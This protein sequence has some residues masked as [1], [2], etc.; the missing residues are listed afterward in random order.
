MI[1]KIKGWFSD[2]V[3]SRIIKN[4]AYLIAS[5][6]ISVFLT[7]YITRLL[8]VYNYGVLGIITSYVTNVNRF[9]SFRMNE[10]VV[11]YV[12]EPFE[13]MDYQ[14]AGALIKFGALIETGTSILSFLFLAATANLGTRI[15]L[16]DQSLVTPVLIYGITILTSSAMETSNGVLRVI[17]RY[18]SI[19]LVSLIQNIIVAILV[20]VVAQYD[21]GLNAVLF[22]YFIGKVI[23]GIV[24][25]ILIIIWLPRMIGKNWWKAPIS[26]ITDKKSILRFTLST[27][28]SNTINLFARDGEILW[29]GALL[30]PL[31][32]GYYK[33]A[34]TVINMV[35][36]PINPFIDTTYPEMM[37]AIVNNKWSQL[38]RILRKVTVISG[39]WTILVS[40]VILLVG[41]PLLFSE[42]NLFGWVFHIFPS[43]YLP[44]YQIILILLVGYGIANILF[45]NRTLL[46]SFS[47]AGT[48][49]RVSL[50]GMLLKV[51]GTLLLVPNSPYT[52]EAILLSAYLAGTVIIMAWIGIRS[53]KQAETLAPEIVSSDQRIKS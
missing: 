52:T 39:T 51:V 20:V 50:Y 3:F 24:P 6:L 32:A 1:A 25:V 42:V 33:T 2:R 19:A 9:F 13:K 30:S 34:M 38:K 35:L 31:Y 46:L 23:L 27:N 53:L 44:A 47:K 21:L 22:A 17:N 29:I 14:K 40:L 10:M 28:I 16:D 5:N 41:K 37:R 15:F 45:W 49:T 12:S 48:A 11:R 4:S 43:E 7:I 18:R 36:T 8:G 26:L